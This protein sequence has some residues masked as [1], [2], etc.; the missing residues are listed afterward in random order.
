VAAVS[1]RDRLTA[2]QWLRIICAHWGVELTHQIL[3]TALLEDDHPWIESN[4]R[5]ASAL[6]VLR[7]I[8]YTMLALLRSVSQRSEL[9]RAVPWKQLL[10]DSFVTRVTLASEHLARLRRRRFLIWPNRWIEGPG[11]G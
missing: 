6:A 3:D 2:A 11:L 8:A 4:P 1:A 9:R 7:R 10:Q 5:A